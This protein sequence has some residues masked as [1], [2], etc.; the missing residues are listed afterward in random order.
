MY[1]IVILNTVKQNTCSYFLF[2]L[3]GCSHLSP[4]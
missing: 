4:Y 2:S 1:R 3:L